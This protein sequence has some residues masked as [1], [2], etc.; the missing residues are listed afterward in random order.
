MPERVYIA[1]E[2]PIGVGKTTLARMLQLEFGA[3]TLL[4][5]FEENPFL[6][7]FYADRER[8]AFQTQIV[9][10]LSRYRQQREAQRTAQ[11]QSLISDYIFAKDR[12]F[13]RLN[14]HGDE[15]ETYERLHSAL[16]E[17]VALPDLVVYLRARPDTLMERIALRDRPYERG[18]SRD[19]IVALSHAY[20]QFFAT[21]QE[22]RLLALDTDHLNVVRS[23]A[24]LRGVA[25]QIRSALANG[26]RGVSLQPGAQ[27][28]Q[29]AGDRPGPALAEAAAGAHSAEALYREFIAL[30]RAVGELADALLATP[31]PGDVDRALAS[32]QASL[33]RLAARA[34]Q[35][36]G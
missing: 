16:A 3:E 20:E 9:F 8:F 24:D 4:E 30:Q 21:Y 13:A 27:L 23:P 17:R 35:A 1:I 36:N 25:A 18:M 28:L 31:S 5:I 33:Q 10:L 2:G 29:A 34:G 11:H 32:C 12:L 7:D 22:T 6:S 26:P 14:L 15:L 19:Y